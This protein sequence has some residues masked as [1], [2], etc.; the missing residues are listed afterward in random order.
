[1]GDY[2][3][4]INSVLDRALDDSPG[5]TSERLVQAM[6]YSVLGGGKRIRARLIYATGH[7]LAL[8]D[9]QL[10]APA[11]AVE[12]IHAYSLVHDD[13]PSMDDDD[14]RR[15]Q[16]TTHIAFDPATAILAGDALQTRAFELLVSDTALDA[17]PAKR[18]ELVRLLAEAAGASGMVS[19]QM[20]D[21]AAE[22]QQLT[23]PELEQIHAQ[24]TGALLRACVLMPAALCPNAAASTHTALD[25]FATRIGLAFQVRDDVIDIESSTATLGKTQGADADHGKATYP[26]LMGLDAAKAYAERLVDEACTA[27]R[28]VDGNTGELESI[29]HAIV[30]RRS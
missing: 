20:R 28:Q 14:L 27:L 15:G 1:M 4:R 2:R 12:C 22:G 24:K 29:A 16:P 18:V 19:G 6:R 25:Q 5:N 23:Q 30:E 21:M 17:G 10:D 9:T 3:Q 7:T 26:A 11:A 13:L 8:P